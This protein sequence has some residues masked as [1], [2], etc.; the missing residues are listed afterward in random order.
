MNLMMVF[1]ILL[2]ADEH[3]DYGRENGGNQSREFFPRM[4]IYKKMKNVLRAILL[5]EWSTN[6][7]DGRTDIDAHVDASMF[8]IIA[9]FSPSRQPGNLV[10]EEEAEI[11]RY[12]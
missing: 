7:H 9:I 6:D 11:N 1:F 2:A 4:N 12:C 5:L 3:T 10:D 8:T